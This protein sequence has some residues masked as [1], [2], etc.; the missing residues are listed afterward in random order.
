MKSIWKMQCSFVHKVRAYQRC[1]DTP[2]AVWTQCQHSLGGAVKAGTYFS[3][4]NF[5]SHSHGSGNSTSKWQNTI[6]VAE[7]IRGWLL[8]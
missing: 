5:H 4:P 6:E 1:N 2:W 8:K 3:A 7:I